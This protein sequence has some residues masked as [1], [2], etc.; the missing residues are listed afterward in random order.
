LLRNELAT[1]RH[2][3]GVELVGTRS[4]RD[5]VGARIYARIGKMRQMREIALGDGYGSQN[6]LRQ[7]F[8][9]GAQTSLDEPGG[10]WPRSGVTH[11]VTRVAGDRIVQITE[12]AATGGPDSS[13][14][15][16]MNYAKHYGQ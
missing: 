15:R 9:L 14:L 2:W 5:A 10:R 3:L 7:Y 13:P 4:N 1:P 16:E 12:A 11:T 6:S 8:G